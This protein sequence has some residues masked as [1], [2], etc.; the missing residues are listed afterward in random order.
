MNTIAI[1]VLG[2]F[3]GGI[4]LTAALLV[5]LQEASD[6]ALS[7][8][9]D[10]TEIE[11]K[12]VN[13]WPLLDERFQAPQRATAERLIPLFLSSRLLA[14]PDPT[15]GTA[16][17][18]TLKTRLLAETHVAAKNLLNPATPHVDAVWFNL[19][20]PTR[21]IRLSFAWGGASLDCGNLMPGIG[22]RRIA[23]ANDKPVV[24]F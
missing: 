13:R 4:T 2:L 16:V 12:I 8:V 1:F 19:G 22:I 20:P 9:E 14:K 15:G 18:M 24:G 6:P 17:K 23:D 11:K 7:E 5:G 3:V 21:Q 10:L